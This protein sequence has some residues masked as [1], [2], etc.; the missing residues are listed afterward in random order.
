M[1]KCCGA[2]DHRVVVNLSPASHRPVI[3]YVA[4]AGAEVE[5]AVRGEV[6]RC[7]TR[8][9]SHATTAACGYPGGQL[10]GAVQVPAAEGPRGWTW[11]CSFAVA[12]E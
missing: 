8:P 2:F 5:A 10:A 1:Q 9:D 12:A 11:I 3:L 4:E 7:C 6:Q